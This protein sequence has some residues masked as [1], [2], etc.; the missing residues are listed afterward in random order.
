MDPGTAELSSIA[1][2]LDDLVRRIT[3][4]AEAAGAAGDDERAAELFAVE[5]ALA[6][7]HRRLTR[8]TRS[9]LGSGPLPRG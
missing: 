1:T 3:A 2:G 4:H 9:P 7:A 6:G 5:R 8:M